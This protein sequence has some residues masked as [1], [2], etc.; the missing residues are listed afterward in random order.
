MNKS[1][2]IIPTILHLLLLLPN[3]TKTM[4]DENDLEKIFSERIAKLFQFELKKDNDMKQFTCGLKTTIKDMEKLNVKISVC[5]NCEVDKTSGSTPLHQMMQKLTTQKLD[6]KKYNA[7]K[8]IIALLIKYGADPSKKNHAK[9][10]ES[11]IERAHRFGQNSKGL[12][13]FNRFGEIMLLLHGEKEKQDK[14]SLKNL[15]KIARKKLI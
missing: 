15:T 7:F 5:L 13:R 6:E 14:K 1:T 3:T 12:I 4:A 11:P 2:L 9:N 8:K 10:P